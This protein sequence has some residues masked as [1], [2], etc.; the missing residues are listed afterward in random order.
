ML[1]LADQE[2]FLTWRLAYELI[3]NC[4]YRLIRLNET[5][6]EMWFENSKNK[7]AR[8][9]RLIRSDIDWSNT[10]VR[11]KQL[12]AV[13]GEK[14]RK[15]LMARQLHILN[16]Y[17]S[18]FPPVDANREYLQ[19]KISVG[20]DK[21]IIHTVLVT[22]E[23]QNQA[24]DEISPLIGKQLNFDMKN[25]YEP[26]DIHVMRQGVLSK[27]A[28]QHNQE[29]QLFDYSKPFFTYIFMV[30][31]IIVFILMELN[32]GS[33]NTETL[34]KFGAKYNPLI[35]QGEWWR[36]I[37]PIFLHIGVLHLAMNTLALYYL[38]TTVEKMYGRSR[39]LWIYLFS[40]FFGALASFLFTSSLSAGASGAIFGCF[41]ALL[42]LGITHPQL[43]FRTMGMNVLI[44]IGINLVFGFSVPGID[45]AG[46]IGGLIGGFL[47]T[48]VVHFPK[49]S[50][51]FRQ[52]FF[53][54][55][56]VI[57]TLSVFFYGFQQDH[58]EVMNAI[59]Q[60]GIQKGDIED[61]YEMVQ[62]YVRDGKGNYVTLF[63]LAYLEI[64]LQKYED[65]KQHLLAA[66]EE[67]PDFHEAHYNIAI[68]YYIEGN[69][70]LAY[71]HVEQAISYSQEPEYEEF[72]QQ[73]E[74]P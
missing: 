20:P 26:S 6:N 27:V 30:I 32:G 59:V 3:H 63:Q 57:V 29:R 10:V 67:K 22:R 70:E 51:W 28:A 11:D 13:Q 25:E 5:Q 34:I 40:G 45:N 74:A 21:T 52:L 65:A 42:Y 53:F 24:F 12:A 39:F 35:L 47:A 18:Q 23:G 72:L 46:H 71:Q 4:G 73:L 2:T 49:R 68:I 36:F 19:E 14:L 66:L 60:D 44:L 31:Q 15:H 9:I 48:G 41:G 8:M 56:L 17:I 43:F 55:L 58:P 37:T 16:I 7:K 1:T 61:T 38:G 50:K 64:Q 54:I 33:T 69:V 62:S